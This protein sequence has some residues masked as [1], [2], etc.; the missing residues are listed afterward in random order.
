[1]QLAASQ[2]SVVHREGTARLYRFHGGKLDAGRAP[3]LLVPSVI[4]RWYVLDLRPGSSVVE[5]LV[6]AGLDVWLLD[7]GVPEDED[8]YL[9][10]DDLIARLNRAASRVLRQTKSPDLALLGYCMGATL[11]AIWAAQNSQKL[12]ALI[13]LAGPIDFSQAGRLG[14]MVDRRWFDA[15]AIAAA[16]NVSAHQMQSGFVA[17]RPTQNLAKMVGLVDKIFDPPAREAFFAL[18]TWASDNVPFP[19]AAYATYIG[20]LYQRNALIAGEHFVRGE[21]VDLKRIRCPVLT[22]AADRDT[23]CPLPAARGLNEHV[24]SSDRELFVI[25]GG[26]VGAVVGSKAADLLYPKLASWLL[27]RT[28]TERARPTAPN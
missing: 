18:E 20:E 4:N 7:W 6:K 19:G 25:P 13:N 21:R 12:R 9:A 22:V 17:L 10:W 24:A 26:H 3:V 5:A 23:I 15:E 27:A 14:E 1:M 28:A 11:T 16:G 2:K 8:R